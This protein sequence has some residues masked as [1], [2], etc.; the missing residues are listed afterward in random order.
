MVK[1]FIRRRQHRRFDP[2]RKRGSNQVRLV[3]AE[4]FKH[5]AQDGRIT[6][7]FAQGIGGKPGQR[8]QAP[9]AVFISQNPA[10]RAKREGCRVCGWGWRIAKNCQPRE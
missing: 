2:Q 10:Q 1:P 6:Q 8:E 4:E 7:P 5:R 3:R 9:G